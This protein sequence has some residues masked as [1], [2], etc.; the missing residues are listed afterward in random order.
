MRSI[1]VQIM[2]SLYLELIYC[3]L[4]CVPLTLCSPASKCVSYDQ[5]SPLIFLI[6]FSHFLSIIFNEILFVIFMFGKC[7]IKFVSELK[8]QDGQGWKGR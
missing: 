4:I 2:W 8:V 3:D 6:K 5:E 1:K 7:C